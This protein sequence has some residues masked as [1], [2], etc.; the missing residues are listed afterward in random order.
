MNCRDLQLLTFEYLDGSLSPRQQREAE[1][2]LRGCARCGAALAAQRGLAESISQQLQDE[3]RSLTLFS[4][5]SE[6]ILLES[7]R[8]AE[9][10]RSWGQA[11]SVALAACLVLA[12]W[13]PS[14]PAASTASA[15]AEESE[16]C[17][18][19]IQ[20]STTITQYAFD[21]HGDQVID[22]LIQDTRTDEAS[23]GGS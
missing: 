6:T 19:T 8:R 7:H 1:L 4:T 12:L 11:G 21:R 16:S 17:P 5:V 20:A 18:V 23:F 10:R 3:T 22:C 13:L 14:R 9:H 15:W 2:H